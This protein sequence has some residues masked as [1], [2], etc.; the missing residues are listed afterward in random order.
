[1]ATGSP[2]FAIT[3]ARAAESIRHI[4]ARRPLRCPVCGEGRLLDY[5][6]I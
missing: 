2:T 6:E 4:A 1:M 5:A 3:P